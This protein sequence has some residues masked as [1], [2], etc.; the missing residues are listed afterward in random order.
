MEGIAALGHVD[1]VLTVEGVVGDHAVDRFAHPQALG[2]VNK[3]G[4]GSGLAHLLELA[5]VLLC[6]GPGTVD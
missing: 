4:G 1:D 5:S 6:V 2:V 3:A